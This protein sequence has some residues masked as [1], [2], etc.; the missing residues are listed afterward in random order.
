[1]VDAAVLRPDPPGRGGRPR[2][3]RRPARRRRPGRSGRAQPRHLQRRFTTE[4]GIPPAAYV[5][6]VRVE[7]AQRALEDGGDPLEAIARRYG[8]G[9]A[10]T[11]RRSFHRC[12]GV[13]PPT[14]ATV[15]DRLREN[16]CDHIRTA[17]LRHRRGARLRR[18]LGGLHHLLHPAPRRRHHAAHR[19]AP[20]PRP[21]Q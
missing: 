6:R 21:Q 16:T 11:L 2:R 10:E 1:M 15:S 7:A 9:T 17:A 18:P 12:L 20:R 5:E 3:P 14:T 13:A 8:F 4:L 19:R